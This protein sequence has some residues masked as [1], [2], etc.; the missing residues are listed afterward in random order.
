MIALQNH[1]M[2]PNFSIKSLTPSVSDFIHHLLA[3]IIL[4]WI[5]I[6]TL[7]SLVKTKCIN[8]LDLSTSLHSSISSIDFE[9]VGLLGPTYPLRHALHY[10]PLADCHFFFDS[11]LF[12]FCL[13]CCCCESLLD[14]EIN[15]KSSL[16]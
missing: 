5:F 16:H 13:A 14:L 6:Y 11:S 10:S 3:N 8:L 4:I 2:A 9:C 7:T 1:P 15:T 12:I